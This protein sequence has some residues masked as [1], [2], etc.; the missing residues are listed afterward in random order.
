MA[1]DFKQ[2]LLHDVQAVF[3]GV[4]AAN[5]AATLSN[6]KEMTGQLFQ[7]FSL[8]RHQVLW[9][10]DVWERGPEYDYNGFPDRDPGFPLCEN[11]NVVPL[12]ITLATGDR[13]RDAFL[14][15]FTSRYGHWN[16]SNRDGGYRVLP[17]GEDREGIN[18]ILREI[19]NF[20]TDA[21]IAT[22]GNVAP[23]RTVMMHLVWPYVFP[24][25]YRKTNSGYSQSRGMERLLNDI[26]YHSS[27]EIKKKNELGLDWNY[28]NYA[29]VYRILLLLYKTWVAEPKREPHFDFF[30][31]FLAELDPVTKPT[32]LLQT[33]KAL[34]LYGVPGTG[35]TH[36]AKDLA[37]SVIRGASGENVK[38]VQFHPGYSY[39][40]FIIGIRPETTVSGQVNYRTTKGVLYELAE[41]AAKQPDQ[42]FCL[43]VDEIN[44]ANLAEVLGEAMYCLEYRGKGHPIKLSQVIESDDGLFEGGKRFYLPDNLYLIGTMNHADRS[45]SGFDMALRRR[46]AWY[47]MEPMTWIGGNLAEQNFDEASLK[48]FLDAATEL[49]KQISEGQV[50][51]G[52]REASIPLNV[53]HQIGD[54]YFAAIKEIVFPPASPEN[55]G[56]PDARRILPQHRE[57][58]WLYYLRPLLEDY[59]GNDVHA[60]QDA[61]KR[62]GEQFVGV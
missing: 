18:Q 53:D 30:T 5:A 58:L 3:S 49:N 59:L 57:T 48:S 32:E 21:A 20:D 25:W 9:I 29:S 60:Y 44:R 35:K 51:P 4:D 26:A 46:F 28:A 41:Q 37:T 50:G 24:A 8:N 62:L 17:N 13:L 54:S 39:A 34:V 36:K 31:Q 33:K 52:G 2:L 43:I 22:N 19:E 16:C 11:S 47:R 42:K 38:I 45:I 1:I 56:S 6:L 12:P 40:D 15:L 7:P 27:G 23:T 14:Y 61:L 55:G 10:K